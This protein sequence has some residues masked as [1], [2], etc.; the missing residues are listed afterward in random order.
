MELE[1]TPRDAFFKQYGPWAVIAG[2]SEG[3]G[4]AFARKIAAHGINLFLIA[5]KPEPLV[6]LSKEVTAQSQVEVRAA[7]PPS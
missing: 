5:C 7:P 3:V 2:G 4:A 6:A 1:L